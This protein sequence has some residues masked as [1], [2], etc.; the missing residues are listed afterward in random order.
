MPIVVTVAPS[1]RKSCFPRI[2]G[3]K[4]RVI[5]YETFFGRGM[6]AL[7]CNRSTFHVW[8]HFDHRKGR[9]IGAKWPKI[10]L[11][12]SNGTTAKFWLTQTTGRVV[13]EAPNV[14]TWCYRPQMTRQLV[15]YLYEHYYVVWSMFC[16]GIELP[17]E[18]GET[19]TTASVI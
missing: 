3:P 5:S 16:V 11:I 15:E 1:D 8:A 18:F 17:A 4:T 13:L 6:G 19:W 10:V 14:Q 12:T 7:C 9:F 2:N